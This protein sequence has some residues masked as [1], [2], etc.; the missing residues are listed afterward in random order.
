MS[1]QGACSLGGGASQRSAWGRG[2][3]WTAGQ[4]TRECQAAQ[5][6][7]YCISY[8]WM[9][10]C[11]KESSDQHGLPC[12]SG[13]ASKCGAA[14]ISL[15]NPAATD[16]R[17]AGP[18]L[19]CVVSHFFVDNNSWR[20]L[21]SGQIGPG[22]EMESFGTCFS[23][24]QCQSLDRLRWTLLSPPLPSW[25]LDGD[26]DPRSWSCIASFVPAWL[27]KTA[28][29]ASRKIS[30]V[31]VLLHG[32]WDKRLGRF[33]RKSLCWRQLSTALAVV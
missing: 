33:R 31:C 20:Q 27:H 3:I 6:L 5:L 13:G 19:Y 21:N 15:T 14:G 28:S 26:A 18:C 16:E 1:H 32:L 25:A 30:Q 12:R 23:R 2:Y 7:S 10:T 17:L 4:P 11:C 24:G 9:C 29:T 22:D 8:S